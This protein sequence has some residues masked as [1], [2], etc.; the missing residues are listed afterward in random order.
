MY[1]TGDVGRWRGD[2][3]VAFHGRNDEQVKIRGYRIELGEIEVQLA[4]HGEVK[5]A[6]VLVRNDMAGE[7]R[8]IAYV[9]PRRRTRP[10]ASD[11]QAHL[12]RTLPLYMVP[13]AFVVLER[14]PLTPNGKLN[15]H[16]LPDP[17]LDAYASR[18]YEAPVGE[19]EQMLA[20]IWQELLEVEHVGRHDNFFELGGH[21]LQGLKLI[22]KIAERTRVSFSMVS[23]FQYPT[24]QQM[25]AA[26]EEG[27][28]AAK[29]APGDVGSAECEVGTI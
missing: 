9:T 14:F 4:L 3:S 11:L 5:E 27:L 21:S 2:G 6:V 28:V 1:R 18:Q 29:S 7:R 25:A 20:S 17:P 22:S 15:R 12:R 8:L 10:S 16:A 26:L 23:I 24:I 13:S 19:A